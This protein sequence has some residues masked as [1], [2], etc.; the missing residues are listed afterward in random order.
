MNTILETIKSRRTCR[1][2]R[3]EQIKDEELNAILEAGSYAPSGLGKQSPIFVVVQDKDT[4]AKV[5]EINTA[6]WKKGKDGFFGAPTVIIVLANPNLCHTYQLDAM[7]CVQNMLIAAE[8]LGLG[9]A[10]ISRAK[11]EFETTFGQNLLEQLGIDKSY[12]GV[13]HVILGY[14]DGATPQAPARR[15]GRIYKI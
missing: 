11:D 6:L 12:V 10:C 5:S 1:S 7:A 14:R 8:S 15:E 2:F 9:A 4:I 13:E 3:Q